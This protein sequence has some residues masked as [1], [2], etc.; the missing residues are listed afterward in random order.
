M[1]NRRGHIAALIV[2]L[3]SS[4]L[5]GGCSVTENPHDSKTAQGDDA[6]QLI[7]SMRE[8]GS[9]EEARQ[10]LTGTAEVIADRI[11]DTVP[12]QTWTFTDD[13]NVQG[14][15]R[16]GLP[17]ENLTGDIAGRPTADT[18]VF[19]RTFSA[20]EFS[21]AVDVV[22]QEAATYGATSETSLFNEESKRD[23]NVQGDGYEFELGQSKK[24]VL[25]ITGD[26]FLKQSVI[27]LPT[28]QLPP[29]P[30]IVPTSTR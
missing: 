18:V 1:V 25:T 11:A 4:T 21:A 8:K 20:D 23:F 24:A 29:E 19:A 27:N 26:C 6:V 7:D 17:C 15:D 3:S 16:A 13:P 30:P 12:G 2:A 9:F 14:I 28:G 5:I 10:R 22:R